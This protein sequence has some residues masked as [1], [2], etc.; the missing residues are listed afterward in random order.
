MA[1]LTEPLCCAIAHLQ[2]PHAAVR[3]N[4]SVLSNG[5]PCVAESYPITHGLVKTLGRKIEEIIHNAQ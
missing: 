2:H 1:L 5:S 4:N 3:K